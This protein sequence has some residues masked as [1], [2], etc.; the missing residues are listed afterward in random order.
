MFVPAGTASCFL[1]TLTP[2]ALTEGAR[3][4]AGGSG[5][6]HVLRAIAGGSAD[7]EDAQQV[8][9][10]CAVLVAAERPAELRRS[11]GSEQERAGLQRI[12]IS[13]SHGEYSAF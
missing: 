11:S 5:T 8:G 2:A 4:P 13:M 9:V 7:G 6:T 10:P 1:D 3:P 12:S